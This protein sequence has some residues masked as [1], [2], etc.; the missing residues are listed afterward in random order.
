[1]LGRP[2]MEVLGTLWRN[3]S[4]HPIFREFTHFWRKEKQIK[5]IKFR[6]KTIGDVMK[7][8]L[9]KLIDFMEVGLQSAV[10]AIGII[11][12]LNFRV[13]W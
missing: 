12:K 4:T 10:I 1:M 9:K 6:K 11:R 13:Q 5:M 3:C 7:K 2:S 8:L